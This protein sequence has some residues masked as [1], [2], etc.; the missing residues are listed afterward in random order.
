MNEQKKVAQIGERVIY[1]KD[2]DTLEALLGEQ[3]QR[4]QG[5]EGRNRL[6]TELINQE[7]LYLDALDRHYDQEPDFVEQ[8][9]AQ[10]RQ[11]L[12]QYAL[13][14][15]LGEVQV[16][17]GEVEEYYEAHRDKIQKLYEFKADHILVASEEEAHKVK[18]RLDAG[19]DFASVAK[20]VSTCPSKQ[21]GGDLGTFTSGQM[22]PE[23]ERALEEM[24]VDAV[25]APVKTQF[26]YHI[27]HLKDRS[28]LRSDDLDSVRPRLEQ[29]LLLLHQQEHYVNRIREIEKKHPVEKFF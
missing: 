25:S 26:G 22:V 16:K 29:E 7:L 5:E 4:F 21:N 19:E 28:V 12:Q 9:E 6:R 8:L 13:H 1:E 27:I 18:E 3:G 14:R 11:L 24:A 20:D 2:V 15:L 17:E 23:F 10:K